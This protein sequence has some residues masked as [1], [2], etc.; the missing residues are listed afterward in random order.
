MFNKTGERD[1]E[2][3]YLLL[4][5]RLWIR[6]WKLLQVHWFLSQ[7][8]KGDFNRSVRGILTLFNVK[9]YV[10]LLFSSP[11]NC[12]SEPFRK[13]LPR[14][15]DQS[16]GNSSF[17][18]I[19]DFGD[20]V[21]AYYRKLVIKGELNES[22]WLWISPWL[23][24]S[25]TI[26]NFCCCEFRGRLLNELTPRLLIFLNSYF[27]EK[28]SKNVQFSSILNV[29]EKKWWNILKLKIKLVD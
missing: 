15:Y 7:S 26:Q 27:F 24:T 12:P 21:L 25:I 10:S 20:L 4:C 18:E 13:F 9:T 11:S 5:H 14:W 3:P 8:R 6:T 29:F 2:H 23:I 16:L 28:S 19:E 1:L 17:S 22:P